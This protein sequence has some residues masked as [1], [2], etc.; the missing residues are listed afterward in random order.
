MAQTVAISKIL[1]VRE[2]EKKDAQLAYHQSMEFFEKVA[3]Q[4]YTLLKKKEVAE[5]TQENHIQKITP[6]DKIIEQTTY[7]EMLNKQIMKLQYSVKKARQE[8]EKNQV[9]L[10]DAHIEVK[11]FEKIVEFREKEQKEIAYKREQASMD[12]ISIQQYLAKN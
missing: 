6:I 10:T 7:I 4:M 2:R 11:K 3:S 5:E 8:M 9:K 1:H 12:E